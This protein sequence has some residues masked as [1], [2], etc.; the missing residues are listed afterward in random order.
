MHLMKLKDLCMKSAIVIVALIQYTYT[1]LAEKLRNI[2]K[3]LAMAA[4]EIEN[5][6]ELEP[7]D[8]E[9]DE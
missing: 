4:V 8:D 5:T 6:P 1:E 7:E 2:A 3:S 9:Y